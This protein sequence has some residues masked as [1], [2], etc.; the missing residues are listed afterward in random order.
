MKTMLMLAL[1]L[2]L[3]GAALAQEAKPQSDLDKIGDSAER[4]ATKPLKDL[5]LMKDKIPP[6][7][8]AIMDDPYNIKKLRTCKQLRGAIAQLTEALGPDVDS[9]AARNKKDQ[10]PAEFALSVGESVVGSLIPG[11][12]IIRKITG[13]DAAQKRAQAAVLAGLLRRA[14]IKGYAKARGCKI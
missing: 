7:V 9:A 2:G 3:S 14:H 8:Q 11:M 12:G 1:G 4:M 6:E 5:N 10:N 13:A